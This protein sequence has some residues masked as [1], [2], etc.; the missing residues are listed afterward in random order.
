MPSDAGAAAGGERLPDDEL[1]SVGAARSSASQQDAGAGADG[2]RGGASAEAAYLGDGPATAERSVGPEAAYAGAGAESAAPVAQPGL[3]PRGG[4]APQQR[5]AG[6][7][8]ARRARGDVEEPRSVQERRAP[9]P[10]PARPPA[11]GLDEEDE[12][13]L[14]ATALVDRL[15]RV[16][17]PLGFVLEP[18]A[19]GQVSLVAHM[20]R[21]GYKALVQLLSRTERVDWADLLSKRR[22]LDYRHLA[23]VGEHQALLR[24]TG[25]AE[26]ARATLWSW[27]GLERLASLQASLPLSPVDLEPHFERDGLFEQ[28]LE[29]FEAKVAERLA[30]RGA[31]S[32][33]L[34]RLNLLR[35]PTVFLL[36]DLVSEVALPRDRV[37]AIL[38][39]LS[40][41]PFA[42]LAR[43]DTG[44]F[45]LRQPVGAALEALSG[46]ALSLRE[47]LPSRHT[48][49]LTGHGEPLLLDEAE[50]LGGADDDEQAAG[51]IEA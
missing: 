28:G 1:V 42:L 11:I 3:W 16:L 35:A 21:R 30:E 22:A 6:P 18:I 48:E 34:A 20:G 33:V 14:E 43:V 39:R 15:R 25:P 27:Q 8:R 44:E 4:V 7:T 49:R 26:L 38:E 9:A 19:R 32:E 5:D 40:A 13:S 41:A 17:T 36:E 2:V 45:V 46:Y 23:V 37:L 31:L 51:G 12:A 10:A 24:L 47:R 50:D 29:R